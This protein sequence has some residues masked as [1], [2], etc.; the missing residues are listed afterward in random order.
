MV[1]CD[2]AKVEVA[3]SNPVSRSRVFGS[4]PVL[5]R[6]TFSGRNANVWSRARY[7]SGKGEVCK[8][9]FD[10][11]VLTA[12]SS[13]FSSR[14]VL[15]DPDSLLKSCSNS[16]RLATLPI[17][18]PRSQPQ[19]SQFTVALPQ[20]FLYFFPE[21]HGH[22]SFRPTLAALRRR[23]LAWA[24]ALTCRCALKYRYARNSPAAMCAMTSSRFSGLISSGRISGSSSCSWKSVIIGITH[25]PCS[26]SSISSAQP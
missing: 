23:S 16:R 18:T 9:P 13:F 21:P 7:P 15:L 22:E 3:G 1:E 11:I 20:H 26:S 24:L 6:W 4:Q 2:L 8:N 12:L 19:G 17:R 10:S 5:R 14:I 25:P